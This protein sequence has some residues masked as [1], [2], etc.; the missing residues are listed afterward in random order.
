MQ[1]V[2]VRVYSSSGRPV[3]G[4]RV[5]VYVYQ[6]LAYGYVPEQYTDSDGEAEFDLDV[7]N[8]AEISISV[9]GSERVGRGRIRGSYRIES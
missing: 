3:S 6:F 2:L 8:G 4:A 9:D 5:N 7:D 1:N